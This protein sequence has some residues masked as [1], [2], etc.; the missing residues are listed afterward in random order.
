ALKVIKDSEELVIIGYSFR[1]EDSNSYLLLSV[2]PADSKITIVDPNP[3]QIIDKINSK[4]FT[5]IT[6][7]NSLRSYLTKIHN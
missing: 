7:Y 4:G 1:Y 3:E 2:L 6:T 5:N